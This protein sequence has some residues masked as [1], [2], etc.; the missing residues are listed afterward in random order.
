M[1]HSDSAS[2]VRKPPVIAMRWRVAEP[3]DYEAWLTS[4]ACLVITGGYLLETTTDGET[5]T[6]VT[7]QR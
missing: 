3:E 7:V 5:W 1:A 2:V 6:P 4:G